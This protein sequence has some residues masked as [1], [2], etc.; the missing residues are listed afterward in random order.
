MP[1]STEEENEV[2]A[3]VQA[4]LQEA[5]GVWDRFGDNLEESYAMDSARKAEVVPSRIPRHS[6]VSDDQPKL[7]DFIALVADMRG[8]SKHLLCAI[9]E[10][11]AD[12]SELQRVYI[13]TAA[14]LPALDLTVSFNR[15]SVTE[16]LGDGI[17]ALFAVDKE[18]V[19]DTIR[20]AYRAAKN[21]VGDTRK[22]VN[23]EL[24]NRY[25]LPPLD[26]GVGLAFSP[27][28]IQLVGVPNNKHAKAIGRCV[29]NATKLSSG[30]N[31]IFADKKIHDLWP[32]SEGGKLSFEKKNSRGTEG[33]LIGRNS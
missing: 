21:C 5:E 33:Y 3:M 28:I 1:L 2:R 30:I 17:L 16:Y 24:A 23:D 13:E 27:A 6:L 4:S 22:I 19:E 18:E 26:I 8:S 29:Y 25:R 31:Q 20:A 10:E 15:G 32:K 14:L 12:V 7:G 9:S 11:K